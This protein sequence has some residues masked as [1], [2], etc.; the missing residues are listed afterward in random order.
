MKTHLIHFVPEIDLSLTH[1]EMA[2]L[3]ASANVHPAARE[4]AGFF[5][6]MLI[7]QKDGGEACEHRLT[8]AQVTLLIEVLEGPKLHAD[9]ET[10]NDLHR[11]KIDLYGALEAMAAMEGTIPAVEAAP[12]ATDSSTRKG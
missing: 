12:P 1:A 8:Q 2:L 5:G 7:R 3:W 9:E 11:L 4:H 10:L 6:H